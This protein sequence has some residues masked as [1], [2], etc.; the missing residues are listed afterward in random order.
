MAHTMKGNIGL[1][2]SSGENIDVKNVN[3]NNIKSLG[4][5][6]GTDKFLTTIDKKGAISYGT[7][8]TGSNNIQLNIINIKNVI[9]DSSDSVGLMIK[10]STNINTEK[11][12]INKII[13]N[14]N[15]AT[16]N[17]ILQN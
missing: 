13:T 16:T 5:K 3:I 1:F 9:S 17:I 7:V 11:I 14:D 2:I 12:S 10:S 15:S 8:I 6:V 4:Y